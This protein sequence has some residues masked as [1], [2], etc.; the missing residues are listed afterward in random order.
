MVE[1]NTYWEEHEDEYYKIEGFIA[2]LVGEIEGGIG[3]S[4]AEV[5]EMQRDLASARSCLRAF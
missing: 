4:D 1:D 3:Y 5:E 2:W